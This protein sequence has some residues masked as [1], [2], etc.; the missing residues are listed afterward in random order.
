MIFNELFALRE[1]FRKGGASVSSP[2]S[3]P[4]T[5]HNLDEKRVELDVRRNG[6]RS[7]D[8]D[9][10]SGPPL[11]GRSAH[12]NGSGPAVEP[13][14]GRGNPGLVTVVVV[15]EGTVAF[16]ATEDEDEPSRRGRFMVKLGHFL[17]RV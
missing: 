8:K 13:R 10:A 11:T 2:V 4:G 9:R 15:E 14:W 12:S 1:D 7:A 6:R 5:E 16:T 17:C 3:C